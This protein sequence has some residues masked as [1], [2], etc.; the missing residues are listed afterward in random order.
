MISYSRAI[1]V[2][3]LCSL[4]AW[5]VAAQT[6][7][8][9]LQ[10]SVSPPDG[11]ILI[12][13]TTNSVF[14]AIGNFDAFTNVTV[15]GS[16]VGQ[17]NI[18][19]LDDGQPP[20]QTMND[21]TFSKDLLMPKVPVG[22]A[23]NVTLRLVVTGEL[24]PP[25]PLPDPPPPPDIVSATSVVRYVVVP[26]PA[27]DN[28]TN[29]FKIAAEG[30]VIL[31]TNNYASIELGEPVHVLVPTVAASVW[32]TWSPAANT[33]VLID[34][35]GTDFDPLLAVYTGTGVAYLLPVAAS[36]NDALNGLKAHVNFDARAGVTYRIAVA[37]YNTNG[38]G[39]I[40]L[41]VAPGRLPDT[42]G[43]VTTII[44]PASE[45]LFTTNLVALTG[46]AKDPR[47]DDTGV[48]GVFVQVNSDPPIG[49]VGT[50]N[51]FGQLLLPPGTN[52]I[53]AFAL[54][55]AGNVGPSDVIVVRF[56]N[57]T[58][59]NFGDAIELTGL[60][61]V[62]TAVNER[63]SR[64]TGEPLHTGN[65]GGHSIWYQLRAP[66]N[67]ML[68]LSTTNSDFDTLLAVYSGD[69][70]TNLTRLADNDD[71]FPQGD[72][73][74]LTMAV[75]ANQ[76]YYIAVDGY[77]G[78]FGNVRLQYIFTT[79]ERYFSLTIDPP[80]GGS[81]SPPSGLYLANSTL[82]LTAAPSRDFE[83]IGWSGAVNSSDNPVTLVMNQNYSLTA[84][85]RLKNYTEGFESGGLGPLAW[86]AGGNA[87]WLVQSN[88]ASGGR[89]A[90]QSGPIGDNQQSSL[91]LITN[92]LSGTGSFDY[93][94]SSE[95]GWD[96]LEFYLNGTRM[97]RWSGEL[98]WNSFQFRVQQGLNALEWR[99]TKDA[100]FGAGRD[101][102]FIDNLYLPLPDIAIAA[103]LAILP[104]PDSRNRIQVQ[105]LSDRQYVVQIS[106]NLVDWNSVTTNTSDSGTI[107]WTDPQPADQPRRFYRALA[108]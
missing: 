101:A 33:N 92:L 81:V 10:V 98:G 12:T 36:G 48:S 82:Y 108:P 3:L 24:P 63:A 79:M 7:P 31:A 37:G 89:F 71:F 62:V 80:L 68:F 83:F 103:R 5:T 6:N 42:I 56:I 57:P 85:F 9:A 76:L 28:F 93:R 51:W 58:N 1:L 74:Q 44:S 39:N 25:D 52:T 41:R 27:N 64:E 20:D 59:D 50:T 49:M 30:A 100:N 88:L 66:V 61:G 105:G 21:G 14:V 32:W 45:S 11:S 34:L 96:A 26:R 87:S 65:E 60:A 73:S 86:S 69:S 55:I 43:P 54:D 95:A 70:V 84:L 91:I 35:A 17:Q 16:F 19:F 94:V 23:S 78:T 67:G 72:F 22:V 40:R 102:A 18:P 97:G 15:R 29:A 8:P 2:G 99:Y 13:E 77:G 75:A 90:A 38:V 4:P 106:P 53:R 46:T 104:L 47:L 107:Q